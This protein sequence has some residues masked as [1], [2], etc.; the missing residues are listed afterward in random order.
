MTMTKQAAKRESVAT[1]TLLGTAKPPLSA[2]RWARLVAALAG[3][4][5]RTAERARDE[6]VDAVKG[7]DLRERLSAAIANVDSAQA[8]R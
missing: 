5:I 1:T 6:G 4:D 7:H 2:Y 3:C 8:S